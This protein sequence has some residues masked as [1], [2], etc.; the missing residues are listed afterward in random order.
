[1]NSHI[2]FTPLLLN[3]IYLVLT[4]MH[5]KGLHCHFCSSGRFMSIFHAYSKTKLPLCRAVA[6]KSVHFYCHLYA[7]FISP[8]SEVQFTCLIANKLCSK[9]AEAL[10]KR[11]QHLPIR[12]SAFHLLLASKL[13][14]YDNNFDIC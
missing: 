9:Y 5:Q 3:H 6:W 11:D 13:D 4:R 2:E 14:E 7:Q 12:F 1:M 10:M 8:K